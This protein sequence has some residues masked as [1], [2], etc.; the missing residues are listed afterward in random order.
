[1]VKRYNV[2]MDFEGGSPGL[3]EGKNGEVVKY[4]DFESL[5]KELKEAKEW[6][7]EFDM[8]KAF[9]KWKTLRPKDLT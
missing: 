7:E 2:E 5:E 3:Y 9:T 6:I 1:M 8:T 4:S